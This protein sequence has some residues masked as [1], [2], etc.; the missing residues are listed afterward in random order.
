MTGYDFIRP[1][2]R[3]GH[4]DKVRRE[5]WLREK[6]IC[7]IGQHKI[8]PGTPW[9]LEHPDCLKDGGSDDPADLRLAC[10]DCHKVKT[11]KENTRRAKERRIFDKH[12]GIK[13]PKSPPLPG[14]RRS[15]WKHKLTG[16]WQRRED[17]NNC[18][19]RPAETLNK[20]RSR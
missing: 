7:H 5:V 4:P 18:A 6:G 15:K 11:G 3:K 20:L 13:R 14:C 19:N 17:P 16:E 9:H 10:E 2:P 1:A 12:F 8:M